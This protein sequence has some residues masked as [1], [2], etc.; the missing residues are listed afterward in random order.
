MKNHKEDFTNYLINIQGKGFGTAASYCSNI[1]SYLDCIIKEFDESHT[2]IFESL[3][4]TLLE[5]YYQE[6]NDN[7]GLYNV[8]IRRHSNSLSALKAY[9]KFCDYYTTHNSGKETENQG[10]YECSTQ[11]HTWTPNETKGYQDAFINFARNYPLKDSTIYSYCNAISTHIDNYIRKYIEKDHLSLFYS[12]D[13][14]LLN[15]WHNILLEK[16]EYYKHSEYSHNTIKCAFQKYIE[17]A[18]SYKNKPGVLNEKQPTPNETNSPIESYIDIESIEKEISTFT[19]YN[20]PIPSELLEARERAVEIEKK[21]KQRLL[22]N[23]I[24]YSLN[25]ILTQIP[26][27]LEYN[28]T[29]TK[30]KGFC[31]EFTN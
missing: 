8:N 16:E 9:I 24:E 11:Q 31:I 20:Q 13:V 12:I 29:Y 27:S 17:F 19:K 14:D 10:T 4:S 18:E 15:L 26:T 21:K 2:T 25:N 28:I 30:E 7:T 5:L 6:L 23:N 3:D 1:S 22:K